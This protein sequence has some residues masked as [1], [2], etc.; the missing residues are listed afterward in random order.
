[1]AQIM[2]PFFYGCSKFL[3]QL[4][5]QNALAGLDSTE[6]N[7]MKHLIKRNTGQHKQ[8]EETKDIFRCKGRGK[9][10]KQQNA[11]VCP[12]RLKDQTRPQTHGNEPQASAVEQQS[13]LRNET[14]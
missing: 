12:Y 5:W 7:S 13:K 10:P 6:K 14:I 2:L 4:L 3:A 1:M 9:A 8:S 11:Q